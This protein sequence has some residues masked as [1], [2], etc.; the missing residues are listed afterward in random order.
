M[1]TLHELR[2]VY[3]LDDLVDMHIA[4][5]FNADM[6]RAKQQASKDT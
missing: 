4:L 2:T 6:E 3:S 5:N 1:A